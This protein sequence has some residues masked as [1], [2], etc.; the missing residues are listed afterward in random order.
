[1]YDQS[2]SPLG[3]LIA[4]LMKERGLDKQ[5]QAL[6]AVEIWAEIVGE[7]AAR[8][9][10]AI[11]CEQGTLVIE[12]RRSVWRTELQLRKQELVE[13]LNQRIGTPSVCDI[14]FR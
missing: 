4:S 11:S 13:K 10:R 8:S 9:T 5:M 12:V 2:A 1:M 7:S 3:V 6:S 14:V